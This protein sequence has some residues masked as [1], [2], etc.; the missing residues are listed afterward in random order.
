VIYDYICVQCQKVFEVKKPMMQFARQEPCPECGSP[1]RRKFSAL[2][3]T[4]SE[5]NCWDYDKEGLGDNLI[6][7]H[8]E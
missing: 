8:H 3:V 7:R 6:L 4:W 1:A 2:N 5:K